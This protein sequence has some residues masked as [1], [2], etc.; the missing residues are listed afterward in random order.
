MGMKSTGGKKGM[1]G[2]H[3]HCV[4]LSPNKYGGSITW[5]PS[6]Y[7]TASGCRSAGRKRKPA[8]SEL[9]K[10]C[11]DLQWMFLGALLG[12]KRPRSNA[13]EASDMSPALSRMC[14]V[15]LYGPLLVRGIRVEISKSIASSSHVTPLPCS[16]CKCFW[17]FIKT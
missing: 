3:F 8:L 9:L 16:P 6:S 5:V 4:I 2:I 10:A 11:I 17:V 12:V 15:A 14:S 13:L 7:P 1:I